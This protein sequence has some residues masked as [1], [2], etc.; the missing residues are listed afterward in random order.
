MESS[1]RIPSERPQ[2]DKS[3]SYRVDDFSMDLSFRARSRSFSGSASRPL[4][5][6]G[7]SLIGFLTD[8][9]FG[10][11]GDFRVGLESEEGE[12]TDSVGAWICISPS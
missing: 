2:S 9:F 1:S 8:F 6:G 4:G 5:L 12:F 10:D 11:V 3:H 7:P